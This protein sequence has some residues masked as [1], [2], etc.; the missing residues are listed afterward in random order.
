MVDFVSLPGAISVSHRS[1]YFDKMTSLSFDLNTVE[2][3]FASTTYCKRVG[4]A[5]VIYPK[6]KFHRWWAMSKNIC[7]DSKAAALLCNA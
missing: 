4:K 2:V 1:M 7:A 3:D 5:A 6:A